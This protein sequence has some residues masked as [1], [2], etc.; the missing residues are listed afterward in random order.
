MLN[1]PAGYKLVPIEPTETMVV[2]GFESRPDPVFS[3]PEDWEAFAAMTGCQQAAHK[4]RLCYAAMLDAAPTPP[5]V[6]PGDAQDERPPLFWY[7]P[8]SDDGYEGPIHNDRI[9]DVRKRSG[10]WVPLYPGFATLPKPL[11]DLRYH[12]EFIR[13]WNQCLRE[14]SA[15]VAAPTAGDARAITLPAKMPKHEGNGSEYPSSESYHEGYAEG[16]NDAIDA[17]LAAQVP[18]K[19]DAA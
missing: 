1:I 3:K 9:E 10:A 2:C 5:S 19:G 16:W 8:R 17:A 18:H 7:R 14:V 6:A 11:S 4:A 12:G 13:G 15:S